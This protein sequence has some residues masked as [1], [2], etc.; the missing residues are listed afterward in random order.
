MKRC[1]LKKIQKAKLRNFKKILRKYLFWYT[2]KTRL[3]LAW[4]TPRFVFRS[5]GFLIE[6][7]KLK[8]IILM[9]PKIKNHSKHSRILA[10]FKR[11]EKANLDFGHTWIGKMLT[12][13]W[14]VSKESMN[15][16]LPHS[17][18]SYF[19]AQKSRWSYN[20]VNSEISVVRFF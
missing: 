2:S 14:T 19:F 1:H 5:A 16:G 13:R 10:H 17:F 20:N 12:F 6:T 11:K 15:W 3:I 8:K 4:S 7:F 18:V 9:L